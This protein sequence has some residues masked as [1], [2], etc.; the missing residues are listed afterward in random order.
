[1]ISDRPYR[2]GMPHQAALEE[3]ARCAGSQFDPALTQLFLEMMH[4]TSSE[5]ASPKQS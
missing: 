1:M 2:K 5:Y 3:L 4:R